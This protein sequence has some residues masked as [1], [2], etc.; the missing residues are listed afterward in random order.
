MAVLYTALTCL[1]LLHTDAY[2][3]AAMLL[4]AYL[5]PTAGLMECALLL[6]SLTAAQFAP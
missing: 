3:L 6:V 5:M 4:A 1:W 2:T